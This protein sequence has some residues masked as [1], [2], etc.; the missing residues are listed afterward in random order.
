MGPGPFY[1]LDY[2]MTDAQAERL[3][4]LLLAFI[5]AGVV[6]LLVEWRRQRR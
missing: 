3:G 6:L 5:V 2:E 4:I 1:P